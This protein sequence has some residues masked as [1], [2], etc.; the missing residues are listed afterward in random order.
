MGQKTTTEIS[1]H[2]LQMINGLGGKTNGKF[3]LTPMGV[4]SHRLRTLDRS[5]VPPST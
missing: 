4:L 1:T 2:I 5:L 3:P